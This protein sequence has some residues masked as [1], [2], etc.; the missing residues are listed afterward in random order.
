[1]IDV[2][3]VLDQFMCQVCPLRVQAF[4]DFYLT[5]GDC[6][7]SEKPLGRCPEPVLIKRQNF[8]IIPRLIDSQP[9]HVKAPHILDYGLFDLFV[10]DQ[11]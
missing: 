5:L 6:I 2:N 8:A 1:M 11:H 3:Y 10:N 7:A 4:E 9:A